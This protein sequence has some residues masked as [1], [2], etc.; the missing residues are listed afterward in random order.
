[1]RSRW[2]TERSARYCH[3]ST[4]IFVVVVIK[5]FAHIPIDNRNCS[6]SAS[7]LIIAH[8]VILYL[9]SMVSIIVFATLNVVWFYWPTNSRQAISILVFLEAY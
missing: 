1:M 3:K 9:D 2:L 7:I 4:V 6:S 5:M 8:S